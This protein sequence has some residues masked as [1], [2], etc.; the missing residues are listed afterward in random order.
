MPRYGPTDLGI[1]G[2]E[3]GLA[4]QHVVRLPC[5]Q[6]AVLQELPNDSFALNESDRSII[7]PKVWTSFSASSV[8]GTLSE[9]DPFSASSAFP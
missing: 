8:T 2:V 5:I 7:L 3:S 9:S 6:A 4:L 1:I